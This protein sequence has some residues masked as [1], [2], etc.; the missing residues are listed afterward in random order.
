[1]PKSLLHIAAD[2]ALTLMKVTTLGAT[3]LYSSLLPRLSRPS[4][5]HVIT[6]DN[7]RPDPLLEIQNKCL[8]I[9]ELT[10]GYETNMTSKIALKDRKISI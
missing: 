9:L 6:G 7:L 2:A 1:M 5:E 3:T 4:R 8:Y 10:I